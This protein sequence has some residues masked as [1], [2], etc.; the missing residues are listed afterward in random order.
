MKYF[1][2]S[3]F[4]FLTLVFRKSK[5]DVIFYYPQHFNRSES[6]ENLYFLDMINTCIENKISFL[7]FEE[8]DQNTGFTRSKKSVPFDFLF[9]LIKVLRKCLFW[10]KN[11]IKKDQMIGQVL[12]TVLFN[13]LKFKNVVTISQSMVSF[14]RG[15]NP[16][17]NI[18]DFQH[19][20]I[21]NNK[22]NY[23]INNK[24]EENLIKNNVH[25]L[26]AGQSFQNILIEHDQSSYFRSHTSVIGSTRNRLKVLHK[27]FNN[28][29]LVTLQFTADH[30]KATNRLL[31]EQLVDYIDSNK[32]IDFYL[33]HHPRFN[34][35]IDLSNL[36]RMQNV[37]VAPNNIDLCFQQCSLHLTAYSTAVFEAALFGIP[38]VLINPMSQFNFFENDFYYPVQ[39]S[40]INF[41]DDTIYKE[42]SQ[43]L[44]DWVGDFY[45]NYD[46]ETFLKLLK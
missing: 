40:V 10:Q 39:Y 24:A 11:T 9:M 32:N 19:G 26:L 21:H 17:C 29:V 3:L 25:L 18:Y 2:K 20:V 43:F 30:N 13:K 5:V 38:S 37:R 15:F 14:F 7:I 33:R 44:I 35:E 8:P 28:N 31:Y 1:F 42:S 23:I 12:N 46:E 6:G 27:R 45:T 16:V 36:F 34:N 4:F 41:T 22:K